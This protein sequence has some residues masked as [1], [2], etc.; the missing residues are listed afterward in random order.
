MIKTIDGVTKITLPHFMLPTN[1][2]LIDNLLIDTGFPRAAKKILEH[3]KDKKIT[4][5]IN[6]HGH[7]DHIGGNSLLQN[8]F[9]CDIFLQP[10]EREYT[11]LE[12][13]LF[14]RPKTFSSIPP[15]TTLET[16][17]YTFH[18]ID[19]PG[20]C[21]DHITLFKPAK[22]LAFS[23]D[24]VLHG[25]AREVS[26]E[27]E[28]YRAIDSLKT[29]RKL[30]PKRI[31]PGHGDVFYGYEVLDEKIAYLEDLG[32][33]ILDL[34]KEGKTVKEIAKVVFDG[35]SFPYTLTKNYFSAENLVR[36]Y[37]GDNVLND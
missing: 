14:G 30:K 35:E 1:V 28:V 18:V 37:I 26:K 6:T 5:I 3:V 23:G 8:Y 19:T 7:I 31:F 16:D 11:L 32:E 34:H 12:K 2:Y 22:K 21:K 17:N 24:L 33:K 15:L 10:M 4:R 25:E 29:L 20:H 9:H 13:L 27:V 36:S